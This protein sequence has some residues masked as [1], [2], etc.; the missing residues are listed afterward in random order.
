MCSALTLTDAYKSVHGGGHKEG[1]VITKE[2]QEGLEEMDKLSAFAP[3]H[4]RQPLAHEA[5]LLTHRTI[6]P[7][8]PSE[9]V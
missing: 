2:H 3:L 7:C 4:V 9:L 1:I 6:T 8:S 5:I